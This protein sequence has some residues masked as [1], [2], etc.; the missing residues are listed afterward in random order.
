MP[1]DAGL[2]YQVT[3][4]TLRVAYQLYTNWDSDFDKYEPNAVLKKLRQQLSKSTSVV[5]V[6]VF[7]HGGAG[8]TSL[9]QS[10]SHC[11]RVDPRVKTEGLRPVVVS[12]PEETATTF[13]WR[14]VR[15]RT[16]VFCDAAGEDWGEWQSKLRE[17]DPGDPVYIGSFDMGVLILDLIAPSDSRHD[18]HPNA[19]EPDWNRLNDQIESWRGVSMQLLWSNFSTNKLRHF[20]IFVNKT[21]LIPS[22]TEKYKLDVDDRL[23]R[24]SAQIEGNAGVLVERYHGSVKDAGDIRPLRELIDGLHRSE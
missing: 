11:T 15:Q 7:G 23:S 3:T 17:Y 21:N 18:G 13:G 2:V 20:G 14:K 16:T 1:A 9:I 24:L 6:A 19:V 5:R 4:D 8:K 10:L 12:T 22:Y